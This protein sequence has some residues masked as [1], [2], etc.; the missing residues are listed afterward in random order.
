MTVI[1]PASQYRNKVPLRDTLK[2]ET[3]SHFPPEKCSKHFLGA[4]NIRKTICNG[5]IPW[6]R[7]FWTHQWSF[8]LYF[9]SLCACGKTEKLGDANQTSQSPYHRLDGKIWKWVNAVS[10]PKVSWG[11]YP[12]ISAISWSPLI[13]DTCQQ[14]FI[15]SNMAYMY[16]N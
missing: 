10:M 7:L 3:F 1:Q 9:S 15:S 14:F 11:C 4:I 12:K 8:I 6:I 2:I 5:N 16:S 13:P